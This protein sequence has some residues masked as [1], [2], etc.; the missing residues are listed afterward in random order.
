MIVQSNIYFISYGLDMTEQMIDSD[1]A[2]LETITSIHRW[3]DTLFSFRTTR[4]ANFEF[5]PGQFARLGLKSGH[6]I[7]WRAYSIVSA[8]HDK[9]LEYYAVLVPEGAFSPILAE[10]KPGD[11]ILTERA[12][13]GFMTA[14]RFTAPGNDLWM[15]ATGTGL[16]PFLSVLQDPQVWQKYRNL[17][18][19]HGVRLAEELVYQ[20]LLRDLEKNPPFNS[21]AKLHLVQSTTREHDPNDSS[22]LHGRIT[23]LLA[24][25]QLELKTGIAINA[26]DSHIMICGNPDMITDTRKILHERGLRPCRRAVPGHFLTENYW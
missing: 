5:T 2:T 14:T 1:K 16:G 20:P 17:I 18:L 21:Q 12:S 15:L 11:P 24:N 8:P 26:E 19:V 23:T 10:A 25:G 6:D 4:A 3:S 7:L 13:Y 9:E 22:R